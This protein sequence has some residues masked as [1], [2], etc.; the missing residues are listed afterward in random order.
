[1]FTPRSTRHCFRNIGEGSARLLV[2]F[3]PAGMERFFEGHAAMPKGPVDQEAYRQVAHAAG[4]ELIGPPM[5][6]DRG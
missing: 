1:M 3:A 5:E 4:M 6:G 2:M